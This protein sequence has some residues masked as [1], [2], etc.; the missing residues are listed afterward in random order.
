MMRHKMNLKPFVRTLGN[1]VIAHIQADNCPGGRLMLKECQ[2]D[3]KKH[4]YSA[5]YKCAL[6]GRT[7]ESVHNKSGEK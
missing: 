2:W 3:D 7:I 1:A 6:C 5:T 4:E